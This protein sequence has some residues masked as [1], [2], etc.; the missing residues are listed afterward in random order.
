[1]SE[2][3]PSA[4]FGDHL[5]CARYEHRDAYQSGELEHLG[6]DFVYRGLPAAKGSIEHDDAQPGIHIGTHSLRKHKSNDYLALEH[7]EKQG[8]PLH[9][10]PTK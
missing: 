5:A 6:Q 8:V 4:Q 9:Q 7:D 10:P 3:Q 2:P 1:M